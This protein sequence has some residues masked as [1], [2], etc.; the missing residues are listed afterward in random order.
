[1]HRSGAPLTSGRTV[2]W[3][4]LPFLFVSPTVS[5]FV[6]HHDLPIYLSVLYGFLLLLLIQYRNLCHEWNNWTNRVPI[7]KTDEVIA[8]Y[9]T[10]QAESEYETEEL[11]GDALSKAATAAFQ[12]AVEAYN[13]K[14]RN[15]LVSRAA[16]GLPFAL[17][18]LEKES[19]NPDKNAKK[20]AKKDVDRWSKIWLSKVEQA[21][22]S[23]QQLA[24]G[25]KEHSVFVLYRYGQ[26]DVGSLPGDNYASLLTFIPDGAE[27]RPLPDRADG[28]LGQRCNERTSRDP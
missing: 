7:I 4:T 16:K 5:I 26:Y 17:W 11:K 15:P 27:F 19:P 2:L 18:L 25:L 22:K 10:M 9:Q 24:Q 20:K 8:W 13:A 1:M 12:D 14:E 6:P 3:R 21:L 23:T 28:P